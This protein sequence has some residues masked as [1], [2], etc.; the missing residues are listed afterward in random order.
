MKD[1]T[2][3]EDIDSRGS[4]TQRY[5]LTPASHTPKD[6]RRCGMRHGLCF[7][8][9]PITED[10]THDSGS[11]ASKQTFQLPAKERVSYVRSLNSSLSFF[12][13]SYFLPR[14]IFSPAIF[15]LF[16]V[17]SPPPSR[18][19]SALASTYNN[20]LCWCWCTCGCPNIVYRIALPCAW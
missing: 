15:L 13:L 6:E 14:Y 3:E 19:V 11:V 12:P 4:A 17:V 2:T 8:K 5:S 1:E 20:P 7:W 9:R 16:V 10:A 18:W